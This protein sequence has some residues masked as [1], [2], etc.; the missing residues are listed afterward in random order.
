MFLL[1][2]FASLCTHH[3]IEAFAAS[4][5]SMGM[6]STAIAYPQDTLAGAYNPAG[7]AIV[8]QRVDLGFHWFND[9]GGTKISNNINP[10]FN[11]DFRGRNKQN[12]STF[13]FGASII[14]NVGCFQ[15]TLAVIG[16]ERLN[17][18]VPVLL[19]QTTQAGVEYC[20]GNIA[21][22]M[23]WNLWDCVSFGVAVNWQLEHE[24]L[25]GIDN[26]CGEN[27][28]YNYGKGVTPS[29]G[30]LW[31]VCDN[32]VVGATYEPKT[33]VDTFRR[34]KGFLNKGHK[35]FVPERFGVGIA[36]D[37][38]P[39]FTFCFDFDYIRW[40][41]IPALVNPQVPNFYVPL[42]P[43]ENGSGAGSKDQFFYH[44]GVEY[45]IDGIFTIRAG[46]QYSPW[47]GRQTTANI[48]TLD[49]LENSFS[50]GATW[51][52]HCCFEISGYYIYGFTNKIHGNN[53]IHPELGGGNVHIN[54]HKNSAGVA[55][56]WHW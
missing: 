3:K 47:S 25:H 53:V 46:Y 32:L 11:D 39:C 30:F 28:A 51:T 56:G 4:V 52:Y 37:V 12:F 8:G 16:F 45:R 42:L 10:A 48:L 9:N 44:F 55:I 50:V 40:G 19:L 17:Y 20:Q 13:D 34:F 35:L 21:G 24:K 49:S 36:L 23:A 31:Q 54:E 15:F 43:N 27:S 7:I 14:G 29:I 26:F 41:N 38:L 2:F 5:K 33:K 22:I 18:Q 1:V 6:G